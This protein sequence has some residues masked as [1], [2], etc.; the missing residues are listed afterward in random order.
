MAGGL[1]AKGHWADFQFENNE[2]GMWIDNNIREKESKWSRTTTGRGTGDKL[3]LGWELDL[4]LKWPA[5]HQ[6]LVTL[7]AHLER[8]WPGSLDFWHQVGPKSTCWAKILP[9]IDHEITHHCRMEPRKN[10]PTFGLCYH[11][12]GY[13][14]SAGEF[15]ICVWSASVSLFLRSGH[16]RVFNKCLMDEC[17][18]ELIKKTYQNY[19]S[20]RKRMHARL[21]NMTDNNESKSNGMSWKIKKKKKKEFG[22]IFQVALN[23]NNLVLHILKKCSILK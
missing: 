11:S 12:P 22:H 17:I 10:I 15:R 5:L 21:I 14:F 19:Y 4:L 3:S 20:W 13:K 7:P 8:S 18:H 9:W 16:E 6:A 23:F 1:A 2:G